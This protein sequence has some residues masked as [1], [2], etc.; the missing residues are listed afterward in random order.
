MSCDGCESAV[1]E[2]L[3]GVDGV[4][5]V[6]VDHEEGR[7]VVEGAVEVGMLRKAVVEAGYGVE[8]VRG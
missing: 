1:A 5:G 3:S 6:A 8:G 4:E 2:A 7:A